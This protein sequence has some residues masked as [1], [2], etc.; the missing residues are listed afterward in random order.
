MSAPIEQT[1]SLVADVIDDGQIGTAQVL[2]I[3]I[4]LT[5]NMLDGFD[6][7]AMAFAAHSIGE[8]LSLSPERLGLVFSVATAGMM[9]GAMFVA[10]LSDRVGRRT[11]ILTCT[12]FIGT[13]MALTAYAQNLTQL[14]V[15]RAITGLGVG[16]MLASLA[17]I[18]SE[19]SPSRFRSFSVVFITAGYPL[20]ATLGGFLVAPLIPV[21]GWQSV[22][23]AGGVAT[24]TMLVAAFFFVPDSLQFLLHRQ[25]KN[26][27]QRV[28]AILARLGKPA[29]NE[30]PAK[31]RDHEIEGANVLSLLKEGR[32]SKTVRLW[33]A[34]FFCLISLY[35]LL[36]WIPKLV[37]NAGLS[38]STG[39]YASVA[40]NG[41][42]VIG[43]IILGLMAA[44]YSL[45]ALIGSF[46]VLAASGM[47]A[48]TMAD[49]MSNLM[50]YL[51]FIG[52]FISAGFT[53]LYAVAAKLYPTELRATGIGWAIGLGRFGAVVGPYVGGVMIAG[54]TSMEFSFI[55]F[56]APL[57]IGGILAY[58]LAVK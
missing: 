45:S 5:L 49:G 7:T 3:L 43:I 11:M 47:L 52:F 18:A 57:I 1:D 55:A 6:V 19:Y 42:G 21:Y 33:T 2:V 40:F 30:L 34:S 38:E 4:A 27:L 25:P 48:F 56:G 31:K 53:G 36:S 35:F 58:S 23:I 8:D 39:V 12:A 24:L 50:L 28:N 17:A 26:A 9:M 14:V 15:L 51:A 10:P 41:G 29:L 37:V 22:F 54:G 16:S 32:G 20:G 46:L 44:R 13:S